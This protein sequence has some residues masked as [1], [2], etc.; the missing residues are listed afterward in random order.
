MDIMSLMTLPIDLPIAPMLAKSTPAVPAVDA[1]AGGY[2]YE[3]KWDGFRC[4]IQRDGDTIELFS[5]SKKPLT[6]YFPEVV[7]MVRN[8]LPLRCVLDSEI[9]VRAGD[10]GSQR[11]SWEHL[12]QRIH[13][14][15]S[16]IE[17]LSLDTPAELVCFDVLAL[18]DADL[19]EQPQQHRREVLEQ[20]FESIDPASG[21]HMTRS[22]RDQELAE[23]WF[24]RF[25]GA[26]LDGVIAKPRAAKYQTGVRS[27]LK[28]KHQRTAE[29]VVLGYRR[30]AKTRAVASLL[31]GLYDEH[32]DLVNVGGI[33]AFSQKM[34]E[35][36]IDELEPLVARDDAGIM[37]PAEGARSRFSSA[38]D[39]TYVPLLPLLVV[40][41][42]FDHLEGRRFR[43]AV[44]FVRW[45]PDR[46]PE[47]CTLHQV[48][49]AA[50]YDLADV[51]S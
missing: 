33:G 2:S 11:L 3:P 29:A 18:G 45:R 21:I 10:P 9:V 37:L 44:T 42:S 38:A 22:T 24:E 23:Q 40:E 17:R 32:G 35:S 50:G 30:H 49:V 20:I 27:M 26:G 4:I 8:T 12:S 16:R 28:I 39:A 48:D 13:P 6:R 25:E 34:R 7:Q 19:M 41:V 51:L 15:E 36:L 31:L 14:A 1:I 47:S 43:H 46:E 5:R